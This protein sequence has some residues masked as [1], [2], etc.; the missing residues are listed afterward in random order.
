MSEK[1]QNKPEETCCPEEQAGTEET[2]C[3]NREDMSGIMNDLEGKNRQVEELNNR[4]LRLQADFD[5]FRRRSRQEREELSQTVACGVIKE[6]LPVVD[7]F[8][9]AL[10]AGPEQEA[11]QLLTGVE[12]VYRQLLNCLE[13]FGLAPIEAVGCQFDPAVH[14]AVMR[15][16]D[17]GQLEGTVLEELQKGYSVQSRVIRPSMVKV[18]G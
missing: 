16:E 1:E 13:K 12:M 14:E 18:S 3:F 11:A 10:A 15:V 17:S 8:E 9:R 5:N 2:I 7:N 6:L 4:L